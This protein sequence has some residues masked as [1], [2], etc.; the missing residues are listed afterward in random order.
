MAALIE[1]I[2]TLETEVYVMTR[3][4]HHADADVRAAMERLDKGVELLHAARRRQLA[5]AAD[6]DTDDR[7]Q[8]KPRR[9]RR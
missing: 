9:S 6:A 5:E 8:P 7:P 3:D 2:Q 4:G 1:H